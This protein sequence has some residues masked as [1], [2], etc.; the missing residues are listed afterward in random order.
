MHISIPPPN[1]YY[2]E[3]FISFFGVIVDINP[4]FKENIWYDLMDYGNMIFNKYD[5]RL[6]TGGLST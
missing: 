6:D 5:F 2:K 3:T 1:F 4:L